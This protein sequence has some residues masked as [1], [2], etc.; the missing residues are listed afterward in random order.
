[1]KYTLIILA[2]ILLSGCAT[3]K[4]LQ[5][6]KWRTEYIETELSECKAESKAF[7]DT[8]YEVRKEAVSII[9]QDEVTI[10]MYQS[11]IND[12]ILNS[13]TTIADSILKKYNASF[14]LSSGR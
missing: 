6:Q 3:Q 12:L 10:K 14:K 13:E 9:K 8:L 4:T 11:M 2:I 1:M 5:M 7:A